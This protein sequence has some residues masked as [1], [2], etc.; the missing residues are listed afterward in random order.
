MAVSLL[1]NRSVLAHWAASLFQ[2]WHDICKTF[3]EKLNAKRSAS[4]MK[5]ALALITI[6]TLI[7]LLGSPVV[8]A[9]DPSLEVSQYAHTAWKVRDG[10]TKGTIHAI[11]QTPDGYLWLATE[12][13]LLRFDGV[14]T[15]PWSPPPGEH[16]PS[17][18]IRGLL[19]A[20][21]GTVW[22]GTAKGLASWKDGK[23]T[24]YLE[25][26]GKDIMALLEDHEGTIWA[27]G[28][29]IPSG[30]G[31]LCKIQHGSNQCYGKD[32]SLGQWVFALY[33]DSRANLWVGVPAGVWR[34]KPGPPTFYR[35]P[36]WVDQVQ[37][38]IE[39]DNGALLVAMRGGIRQL[40]D[41]KFQPYPPGSG[42]RP[43]PARLLRDR[44]SALWIGT[45]E[46]G[47]L[48]VHQGKTDLFAE[49]DGLS[50]DSIE[51]IFEDR[52]GNIWVA[53]NGGLDRFRDY[54]V[55]TI[56]VKQG[57]SDANVQSVLAA[58]DGSVWL[59]TRDGLNRWN[60]GEFTVFRKG[61]P[62][63][64]ARANREEKPSPLGTMSQ[65]RSRG[66]VREII[67]R[68]LPGDWVQSLFQD[69]RGRIWVSATPFGLAYFENGRFV[70]VSAVPAGGEIH[71]I[72]EDRPGIFGSVIKI[73]AFFTCLLGTASNGSLGPSWEVS[74][75][76][77]R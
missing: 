25:T 45:L 29:A 28:N 22:I 55:S 4:Q 18:D 59:G 6:S 12:F 56:S 74:P 58:R 52:E 24:Q 3:P 5:T 49:S 77:Q 72:A 37:T 35:A 11:A 17:T 67:D 63:L 76:P 21:D 38:L 39:G 61:P 2:F 75:R 8:L 53:T 36:D 50:G 62:A 23:L 19:A 46:G 16:L 34:W 40:V 68:G 47:L 70:P 54:A 30:A 10:F 44:D 65:S 73:A 1:R 31:I 51:R 64:S 60:N 33:E 48:H 66:P 41:E 20:R 32:G 42:L 27:T 13:G 69:D 43:D 71:C 7:F 15:I 26:A 9:L 14:R 57:L